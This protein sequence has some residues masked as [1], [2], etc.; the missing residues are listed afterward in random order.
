MKRMNSAMKEQAKEV[1]G[2]P[3]ENMDVDEAPAEGSTTIA[4]VHGKEIKIQMKNGSQRKIRTNTF[5]NFECFVC[6]KPFPSS[7]SLRRHMK[8]HTKKYTCV[9]CHKRYT[10]D[11]NDRHVCNHQQ[12]ISCE[13]CSQAF[14]S[15]KQLLDHLKT[16]HSDETKMYTCLECNKIFAMVFLKDTH[17]RS[18]D[19]I[20]PSNCNI[21]SKSYA[22]QALL[23][24]HQKREHRNQEERTL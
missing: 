3:I 22:N 24:R 19:T 6:K 2:R 12:S 5:N 15:T 8:M 21:C 20:K 14:N 23:K 13:Y 9:V 10:I 7:V 18:H 4:F 16:A 17:E 1:N 11:Q